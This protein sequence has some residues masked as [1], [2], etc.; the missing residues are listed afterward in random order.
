MSSDAMA[1]KLETWIY[2]VGRSAGLSD[3]PASRSAT[4]VEPHKSPCADRPPSP[5]PYCTRILYL[6]G[7]AG[8]GRLTPDA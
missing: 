4:N 7:L 3:R 1:R 8:H 6:L 5:S 2:I